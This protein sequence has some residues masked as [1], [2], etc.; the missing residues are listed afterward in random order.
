MGISKTNLGVSVESILN[1]ITGKI[2]SS[3]NVIAG[4][5]SNDAHPIS[6]ISGLQTEVDKVN[7]I[8][9]AQKTVNQK[10]VQCLAGVVD[11]LAFTPAVNLA[12]PFTPTVNNGIDYDQNT[13]MYKLKANVTYNIE[14]LIRLIS[15]QGYMYY[16]LHDYT[17][18]KVLGK[19]G[20][21][22]SNVG[23]NQAILPSFCVITPTT[24]ID[25]GIRV[26]VIGGTQTGA[27]LQNTSYLNI[28]EVERTIIDPV[29]YVNSDKGIED[30]PVG[31]I[32]SQ[33][34]KVAPKHYLIC[35]GTIYNIV[36]YPHLSQY[37]KDQFGTFNYFG[38]NG[39]TTFAVPD[40]SNEF[41]RGYYGDKTEKLSGDI[42]KHQ[43]AT[44]HI[45]FVVDSG[46]HIYLNGEYGTS[47]V[48]TNAIDKLIPSSNSRGWTNTGSLTNWSAVGGYTKYTSRPTNTAVLYCIKYEPTYF[49]SIQGLI[50]ET[51]L[52]EGNIG[53]DG[54]T[55]VSN[56]I[57][58]L[59]SID[60]YD[61]L[62]IYFY[63]I[64]NVSTKHYDYKEIPKDE[65]I[66][67]IDSKPTNTYVS[68]LFGYQTSPAYTNILPVTS[69][70][71]S[72]FINQN[73]SHITKVIGI[74]YKTY[75]S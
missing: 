50:E 27:K 59:D 29:E 41:L 34:G 58:L 48:L 42:G 15:Y 75:Q 19:A 51:V 20:V 2:P 67:L 73:Q 35:D 36:D 60:N 49:M 30:C 68:C 22:E 16:S 24:D 17:N 33:M 11:G 71:S 4:R 46:S 72:L 23:I 53:T 14:A 44:Q 57:N 65:I 31:H 74:K 7:S 3:H 63:S 64:Y 13:K 55:A 38:G 40:L 9:I 56:T 54:T 6:A 69:T 10:N 62:G 70:H 28:Q 12:L 25:V 1:F 21:C 52:F 5:D 37:I 32:L 45:N 39:I 61:K 18:S 47:G 43:D 26:T 8:S 66:P